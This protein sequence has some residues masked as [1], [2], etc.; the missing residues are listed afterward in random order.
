M[1]TNAFYLDASNK[2]A[3]QH[4][5]REKGRIAPDDHI[6]ALAKAGEGNM[7]CTLRVT[8]QQGSFI[9]KQARPYIE[10]YPKIPAPIARI[11][12][13]E[14][15]Y[16]IVR[17][18]AL[19]RMHT[20]EVH[21]SEREH[22]LLA[23]EDLGSSADFTGIYRK[24]VNVSKTDILSI[25]K[26]LSELHYRFN[27]DTIPER[28]TNIEMRKLNH[29]HIFDV[30]LRVGKG[31]DLNATCSGL[32]RATT[33]FR[34]D[35]RLKVK[36]RALGNIYLHEQGTTLIHGDYYPGSWLQTANGFRIIDPEFCFF[37]HPEFELAVAVAHLKM[38]Q[39]PDSLI[40]DIFIY[41][42]FDKR[43]DGSL[44]TR[45]VGMEV[46]RRLLG[47]AQL[48]LELDLAERLDLLDQARQWVLKG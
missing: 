8:T 33:S 44:F 38:A 19:L 40:K 12:R 26:V 31:P 18:D 29:E 36:A 35:Q 2:D 4:F 42:H 9:L 13:E 30:P 27:V 25:A 47:M 6:T 37:G 15:F 45:F 16:S 28:M 3:L 7:N 14:E 17:R 1:S 21:W 46:I 23:M 34:S 41:Y 43:F 24:G 32:Q 39:Q 5:L 20:P 48:P 10:R 11:H 22:Y